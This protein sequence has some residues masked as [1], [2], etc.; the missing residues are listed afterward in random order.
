MTPSRASTTEGSSPWALHAGDS[1]NA[2]PQPPRPSVAPVPVDAQNVVTEADAAKLKWSKAPCRFCGR[3]CGVRSASRTTASSRRRPMPQAEVNRGVNCVKGY[4]LSKIMYGADRLT[5]P[6]LRMKNGKLRQERRVRAGVVGPRVRRDGRAVEARAE[7]EGPDRRRHVRLRPVDD[8]GRLR[9]AQAHEGGLSH[10]QPRP[11]RAPLHGVRGRGLHAHVRHRRADGMLRRHRGRRRVR[12]VGLEHGGDAS[13]A[14]DARHRPPPVGAEAT[15]RSPCCRCS[16]TA[17]STSPT[18]PII[19]TP[20]TDLAILELHRELHHPHQS[21]EPRLRRQAHR[22]QDRQ[23]RHRLRPAARARAAE[24]G[25]E[26]GRRRR[27]QAHTRSTS[28]RSSSSAYD[29]SVRHQAVGRSEGE[30][31]RA[32]R[33]VRRSEDQGH[34]VLD[35]GLQPAHARRLGE[36]ALLQPAPAHR[37]DLDAGQQPVLAHRPAVGVRHGARGRHVLA[38]AARGHGGDQSGASREDRGDL[39]ICRRAR[40]RRQPGYPRGAAEPDAEG[41]QAQRVLGA[42]QQQHAGRAQPGARRAI[43]AIAIPTTS[44][45]CPKPIRR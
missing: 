37:Q 25:E 20:Q 23:R 4:Y 32:R 38:S 8:L 40:S 21:R 22:V 28:T 11:Q 45:S 19:F 35:D 13:G 39:G 24:G 34:V 1:S 6:L 36:P 14:V 15:S 7:G 10:Q 29:A 17:A 30:A 31:R 27:Q 44:S 43:P 12:A 16:S 41:R 2:R 3:G 18:C 33:A 9:G 42:G 26:R 5:T